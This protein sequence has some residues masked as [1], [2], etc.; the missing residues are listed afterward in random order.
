ME[1]LSVVLTTLN[2]E[3][4]TNRCLSSVQWAD[5]IIVVDSFS[6][7]RT[8]ELARKYTH[9]IYQHEYPGSSRQ[10]ERGIQYATNNWIFYIDADEEVSVELADQLRAVLN[11]PGDVV[12]YE[13]LRKPSAFGKWIEHGGWFP[14]YAFRFFRKDSYYADHHEV[15]GGFSTKGKKGRLNGILYHHTYETIYSYVEK[16]NEYTSLQVSN[17][18]NGKPHLH[19]RWHNLVLNP[20]S[21]F[22]RMFF[23]NKG[24]KDGFHG[25]VLALLDATYTMLLYAK[26]WEY[27]RSKAEGREKFPPITN[28][29]LNKLKHKS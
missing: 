4:N 19:V 1:K 14:D 8:L 22:L 18:L 23:S 10:V 13:I 28:V 16:M 29:E 15:H 11:N 5:E 24:Y 12:G 27:Q 2:E 26:V 20:L 7:D 25:F 17:K 9:R 3:K 6:R 21:H